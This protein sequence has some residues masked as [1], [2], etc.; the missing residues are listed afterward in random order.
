MEFNLSEEQNLLIDTTKAFVK[1]ELLQHEELLEKTNNLPKELYD[2]IKQKSIKAGLYAC[3]MPTEYGG[4]GLN[5]FDLTLVEKHLCFA[6]LAL[7]EISWRPQNILMACEGE[8]IDEYLKPTITGERKDCIAMT[9]PGAGSDLRGMKTKAVKN[10]NDWVINGTKHFISNAHISDF[11][12]LFASTGEDDDGRNLL[13]CFLVDLK[14]KGVEVAKG[15]DCVSHRGYVNN[16]LHFNDC[17]IPARNILGEKDKGF[18]LMNVWLEATRL[19]VAATSVS[20]AER[21]FDIALDWSASRKQ[22]GKVIGKFQGVSFK[23]ADMATEIKLANLILMESAWKIDQKTLTS[24]DAAMTKL[25]CTEMLSRVSDEAIQI[26]G[27]MGL[28]ADIPLER[29]WRDARIER[30]WEGTSEIQ[31][32]IIS[33]S[34]L[35]PLGA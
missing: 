22:F 9:E 28:M 31:R 24:Q 19:T 23:L 5:A 12:V 34:L 13:S 16:I 32:H 29:I 25:F 2:E 15:Y 7:A 21:A 33:R 1:E 30:I 11:V 26:C 20:R 14:Q 10:G 18:E 3:N 17:R 27:G 6:S 4:G 35:R 8:L